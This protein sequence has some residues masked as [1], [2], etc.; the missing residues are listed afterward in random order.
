MEGQLDLLIPT[1]SAFSPRG[2]RSQTNTRTSPE[3]AYSLPL[4]ASPN[5]FVTSKSF[6]CF[7][8]NDLLVLTK[9]K[10]NHYDYKRMYEVKDLDVI[11]VKSGTFL[12]VFH[13]NSFF[14]MFF[15]SFLLFVELGNLLQII[16]GASA[17]T[18]HVFI[19][20]VVPSTYW[21]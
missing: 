10:K 3:I 8:F 5:S 20:S 13:S 4:P 21:S 7:L 9:Q 16:H 11:S 14:L 17:T 15:F 19:V 12:H 6:Y 18:E 1:P 2:R